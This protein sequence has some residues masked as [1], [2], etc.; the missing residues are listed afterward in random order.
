MGRQKKNVSRFQRRTL[1]SLI[2]YIVKCLLILVLFFLLFS[3]E[4]IPQMKAKW[5][6]TA[7]LI[8][9]EM[10]GELSI[11]CR[12]RQGS[13][14]LKLRLPAISINSQILWL[15]IADTWHVDVVDRRSKNE[16]KPSGIRSNTP[17][18]KW[19]FLIGS[20]F[21]THRSQSVQHG[22]PSLSRRPHQPLRIP[23]RPSPTTAQTLA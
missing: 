14:K 10:N 12:Q 1:V 19:T 23:A 3:Q 20:Q 15:T 13:K 6:G 4:V 21:S 7:V 22:C 9:H 17:K 11:D 2:F 5:D 8:L 16:K 18:A